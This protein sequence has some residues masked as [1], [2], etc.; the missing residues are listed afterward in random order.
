MTT[1]KTRF[2]TSR[3]RANEARNSIEP[4]ID[5]LVDAEP[6]GIG[7]DVFEDLS[8][9]SRPAATRLVERWVEISYPVRLALV[10]EMATRSESDIE[11]HFDRA[12]AAALHDNEPDV[13][14]VAIGG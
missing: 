3:D 4:V 1:K 13:R 8:D 12:L 9:L 2:T 14:L 5:A 11:H 7:D 10:R 6:A